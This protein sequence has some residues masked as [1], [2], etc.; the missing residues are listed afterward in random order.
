MYL[1]KWF[2]GIVAKNTFESCMV[3]LIEVDQN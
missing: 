3:D 1:Y 2:H